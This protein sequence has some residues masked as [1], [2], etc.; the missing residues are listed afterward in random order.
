MY[1]LRCWCDR[2]ANAYIH[3]KMWPSGCEPSC[4]CHAHAT[5]G[6]FVANHLGGR[7]R[8]IEHGSIRLVDAS[9]LD[10]RRLDGLRVVVESLRLQVDV[11]GWPPLPESGKQHA[12]FEHEVLREA[13]LGQPGEKRFQDVKL[14]QFVDRTTILTCLLAADQLA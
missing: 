9:D 7:C 3:V 5:V 14:H 2:V 6:I 4:Y 12:A 11:A 1:I 8:H 13:R 10:D